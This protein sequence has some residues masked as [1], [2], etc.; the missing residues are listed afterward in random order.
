MRVC[1]GLGLVAHAAEFA[2]QS[3]VCQGVHMSCS[4]DRKRC[5][6]LSADSLTN[7]RVLGRQRQRRNLVRLPRCASHARRI[8]VALDRV[9]TSSG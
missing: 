9:E 7:G 4:V 8:I 2:A 5:R 1:E 3:S 6:P